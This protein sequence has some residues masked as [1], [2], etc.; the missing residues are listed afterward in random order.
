MCELIEI[1]LNADWRLPR[2]RHLCQLDPVTGKR[3]CAN[4]DDAVA[5][6][7]HG[8]YNVLFANLGGC[9]PAANE[10]WNRNN[11]SRLNIKLSSLH[12]IRQCQNTEY[13]RWTLEPTQIAQGIGHAIHNILG[14]AALNAF[15]GMD[16]V[17]NAAGGGEN[18]DDKRVEFHQKVRSAVEHLQD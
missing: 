3:C 18:A 14:R 10:L 16:D 4:R 9:L 17:D 1:V 6:V 8:L 5:K 12:V 13:N 7:C 2:L 11:S 15:K